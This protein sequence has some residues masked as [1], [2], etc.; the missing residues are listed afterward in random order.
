MPDLRIHDHLIIPEREISVHFARSGGAGGQHV[1]KVETKVEL[2]FSPS[3][4]SALSAA[5]K[6]W[7]SRRLSN[8]LTS[9]GELIIVSERTRNQGRNREDALEKLAAVLLE[10]LKRPKSRRA[11]RP[12][13]GS[14]QRRL[15]AKQARSKL[16]K[17]RR[18]NFDD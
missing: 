6:E 11:T 12:T 18:A 5:D 8:Q 7:L 15:Q 13:R 2:R 9:E 1:N 3:R 4:S 10:A 14:V 16:K 17:N